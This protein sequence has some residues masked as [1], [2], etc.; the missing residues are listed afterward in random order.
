MKY[1][2]AH[3]GHSN[4]NKMVARI[5]LIGKNVFCRS[6]MSFSNRSE[7]GMVKMKTMTVL[8]NLDDNELQLISYKRFLECALIQWR[9]IIY[10]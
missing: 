5:L 1:P 9:L 10:P 2:V 8:I 4:M 3:S 6:Y 7:W